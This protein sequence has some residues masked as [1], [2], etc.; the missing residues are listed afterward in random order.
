MIHA[1]Q[2]V[3]GLRRTSTNQ[4]TTGA[5]TNVAGTPT[6]ILIAVFFIVTGLI[7]SLLSSDF[8]GPGCCGR[9]ATSCLAT[10]LPVLLDSYRL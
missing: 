10:P 4:G 7:D 5:S 9:G 3:N 2:S 1:T 8:G 6:P